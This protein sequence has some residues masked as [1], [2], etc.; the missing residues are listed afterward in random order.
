MGNLKLM[1]PFRT[2]WFA[3]AASLVFSAWAHAQAPIIDASDYGR[4]GSS[5]SAPVA[6]QTAAPQ[7]NLTAELLA[8]IEALQ[9]E[10]MQLRGQVEEQAHQLETLRQQSLDRYVDLDQRLSQLQ[11]VAPGAA[12]SATTKPVDPAVAPAPVAQTPVASSANGAAAAP[13]SQGTSGSS[14]PDEQDAYREAYAKVKAQQFNAAIQA[15]NAFLADYPDSSLVPNAYYW[16]GELHLVESPQNLAGAEQAFNT[17]LKN[18]PL[19]NKAPDAL[20]KLGR[21][22]FLKGNK[23]RARELLQQVIDDYGSSGS[24]APQLAKQFLDE[25]FR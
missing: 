6:V 3:S 13:V 20:Y 24:A 7:G 14:K 23:A 19:H 18:Y 5:Y 15:F 11:G 21:V 8:Q 9:Q 2:A 16:L 17:L 25:N 12:A 10:V 4:G 22:E 1:Y